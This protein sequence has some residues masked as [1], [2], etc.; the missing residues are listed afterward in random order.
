[1][2]PFDRIIR[3]IYDFVKR[4]DD[5][6]RQ[7]FDRIQ[8]EQDK[9]SSG[10]VRGW[11]VV[12]PF[13]SHFDFVLAEVE[14]EANG[15]AG[16]HQIVDQLR[17]VAGVDGF[18]R[19]EFDYDRI[20]DDNVGNEFSDDLAVVMHGDRLLGFG[21]Q[22]RLSK[23]NHQALLING[24]EVPEAHPVVNAVRAPDDLFGQFFIFHETPLSLFFRQ[25][26]RISRMIPG[27]S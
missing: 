11:C 25:D 6:G 23:F 27:N 15:F 7:F 20:F 24:F 17:L 18:D 21:S 26:N 9:G 3:D 1:M 4:T 14:E 8:D 22:T 16:G 12:F 19:L 13:A 2:Y 10:F 5:G